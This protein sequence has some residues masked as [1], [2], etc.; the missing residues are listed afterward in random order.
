LRAYLEI[1]PLEEANFAGFSERLIAAHSSVRS[2]EW[3]PRIERLDRARFE[4]G[5]DGHYIFEGDPAKLRRAPD[6]PFYLPVQFVYPMFL[7]KTVIGFDVNA[8]AGSR[9]ALALAERRAG[10]RLRRNSQSSKEQL[11]A[12]G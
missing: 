12:M 9:P 4:A 5:L 7:T 3:I 10:P 2:L 8:S 11:T 6:R 1:S